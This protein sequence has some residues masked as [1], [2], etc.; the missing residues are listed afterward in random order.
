MTDINDVELTADLI[1]STDD[2]KIEKVYVPEWNQGGRKG[3]VY[4]KQASAREQDKFEQDSRG[5]NGGPNLMH[6]RA[7][8]VATSLVNAKGEKL[9]NDEQVIKLSNK[10]GA[11]LNRLIDKITALNHV[12][13]DDLEKIAKN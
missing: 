2:M 6:M 8:L 5:K 4:I 9:F 7:R 1:F 3:Y 13:T 10:S 11:V 12:T